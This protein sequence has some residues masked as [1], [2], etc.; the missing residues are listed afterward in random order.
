MHKISRIKL[1][2]CTPQFILG[3][4]LSGL[5]S[6][7]GIFIPL[8]IRAFV[9]SGKEN[10]NPNYSLL[11]PIVYL[12]IAQA[13]LQIS[14]EIIIYINGEKR[15]LDIRSEINNHIL[16]LPMSFFSNESSSEVAGHLVNDTNTV[17]NFLTIE[18]LSFFSGIITIGGSIFAIF[19]LDWKLSL[20]LLIIFPIMT[21]IIVPLGNVGGKYAQNIQTMI[22]NILSVASENYQHIKLIKTNVAEN[23]VSDTFDTKINNLFRQSVKADI[24]QSIVSP[25]GLIFLFGAIGIVFSYGG[26]RVSQ[27]TLTVGTLMSFLIY[28][29]QLLNPIGQF[30][31]F[32]TEYKKAQGAMSKLNDIAKIKI[33]HD[34]HQTQNLTLKSKYIYMKNVNFSYGKNIILERIN[35]TIPRLKKMAIVGPSGAGKSTIINLIDRLYNPTAGKILIG[36]IDIASIDLYKWRSLFTIVSQ[37]NQIISGTIRDNL[38]FGLNYVPTKSQLFLALEKVNLKEYVSSLPQK[39]DTFVGEEG[40]KMSGGQKQ[41]LQ[42]AR[43]YL[44][45]APYIVLD[46]A[47]SNLDPDTEKIVMDALDTFKGKKTIIVIAHRLATIQDADVIYFLDKHKITGKGTHAELIKHHSDYRRFVKEQ[48]IK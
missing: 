12:F 36:D 16:H 28:I 13:I 7:V 15:I 22:S 20:M 2:K 24:V 39:L 44:K 4:I 46:E 40:V 11:L 18:Y 29:F 38:L 34:E 47:T 14:S 8:E 17:K 45:K 41:R 31:D 27:G 48:M 23:F 43:V 21:L 10:V 1:I 35:L 32:F 9:D 19:S 6:V 37:E 25:L 30:A 33:E 26:Y 3:L 42:I 5:G